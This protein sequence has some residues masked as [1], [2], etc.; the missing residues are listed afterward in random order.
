M[1]RYRKTCGRSLSRFG[2]RRRIN[3]NGLLV[4]LDVETRRWLTLTCR[5]HANA[6]VR[7]QRTAPLISCRNSIF[8][9]TGLK[10]HPN[11]FDVKPMGSVSKNRLVPFPNRL[12]PFPN[13]LVLFCNPRVVKHPE[14]SP[15]HSAD[16]PRILD[17]HSYYLSHSLV[18]TYSIFIL[19]RLASSACPSIAPQI[20]QT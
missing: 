14:A 10:L 18:V 12:V 13:R 9:A 4:L 3:C 2:R 7:V 15:S 11:C 5:C 6:C 8:R 1:V 20:M 16:R 19:L 17:V